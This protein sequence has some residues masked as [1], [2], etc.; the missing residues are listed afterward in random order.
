[1]LS[2]NAFS[3]SPSRYPMAAA[4]SSFSVLNS[5]LGRID[6]LAFKRA[7][8]ASQFSESPLFVLGHW[9]SGTTLLH[10]MLAQD[11]MHFTP[12]TYQTFAPRHFLLSESWAKPLV[13][14]TLPEKRP[15][16][17][18]KAGLDYPQEDE[19]ALMGLGVR[20]PY[21]F[22][23]FPNRGPVDSRYLDLRRLNSSEREAWKRALRSFLKRVAYQKKGR[24]IVK[25]PTHTARVGIIKEAIPN[26]KFLHIT[27][28]PSKIFSS[29]LHTWR[30]LSETQGLQVPKDMPWL[31]DFVIQNFKTLHEALKRDKVKL[32]EDEFLEVKFEDFVKNP[33]ESLEK[34]YAHFGLGSFE[35]AREA[36]R[37]YSSSRKNY[38][39]NKFEFDAQHEKRIRNEWKDYFET[40]G[41][42]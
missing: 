6:D 9:R 1:M 2:E 39:K 20:T 24:L 31:E 11:P 3:I 25:S 34:I 26:A 18:M 4:I 19:F 29:T 8:E 30:A 27:R 12:N 28:H 33:E 15:M 17:N 10:E 7:V 21:R 13:R 38:K 22:M 41:Y 14:W 37:E 42:E 5:V 32:G 23:A 40:Y 16:D 35:R 36:V